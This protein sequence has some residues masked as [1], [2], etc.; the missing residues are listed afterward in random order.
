MFVD[1]LD[2]PA[3]GV[4]EPGCAPDYAV[5]AGD[6]LWIIELKTERGSH[7]RG[8]IPAYFEL[9]RHHHPNLRIDLTYL[10]PVMPVVSDVSPA[11]SRFAHLTW[12]QAIP[13]VREVWRDAAGERRA[14]QGRVDR[15]S[16]QHGHAVGH[17][18][19]DHLGGRDQAGPSPG[20]R[21]RCGRSPT[22]T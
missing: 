16:R 7:R 19:P 8:Q 12:G 11:G 18:A 22:R 14:S 15:D 13:L 17:L 10:T 21:D 4:D 3:R 2:L 20:P 6:R 1:E 9:G 5:F